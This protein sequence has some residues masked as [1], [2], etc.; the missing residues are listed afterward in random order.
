MQCVVDKKRIEKIVVC[1]NHICYY[2]YL[3]PISVEKKEKRN[4]FD[5]SFDDEKE[6]VK[7]EDNLLRARKKIRELIWTNE[8]EN[9][10]FLTLTYKNTQLNLNNV[11]YDFKLFVKNLKNNGFSNLKYIYITEHQKKRGL[12]ENNKGSLHIHAVI[13]YSDKIPI[14]IIRKCWG[15]GFVK[16]NSVKKIKNLGAY[17]CKYLTKDEFDE[18]Y[19][20]SYHISRNLEKPL[21]LYTEGYSG[22]YGENYEKIL[23]KVEWTYSDTINISVNNYENSILYKQGVFIDDK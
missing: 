15:K 11:I 14:E 13:F 21:E 19:K 12:K 9:T 3:Y 18:F 6:K 10:K 16:I 22:S 17:V 2:R 5:F 4:I 20:N 23:S 8:V 7:R 1:G